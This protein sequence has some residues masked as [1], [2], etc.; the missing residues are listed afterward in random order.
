M[1]LS[2]GKRT[3]PPTNNKTERAKTTMKLIRRE[4][5]D[6]GNSQHFMWVETETNA[7][8]TLIDLFVSEDAQT[9]EWENGNDACNTLCQLLSDSMLDSVLT[10]LYNAGESLIK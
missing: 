3:T 7:G 4:F 5:G 10:E 8:E 9:W 1:S 2:G 6:N